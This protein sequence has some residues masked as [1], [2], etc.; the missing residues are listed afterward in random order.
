MEIIGFYTNEIHREKIMLRDI[1]VRE[2]KCLN[3]NSL[4]YTVILL[5]STS[6]TD[7]SR[8]KKR[9]NNKP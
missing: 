1:S 5:L 3:Y 6:T 4:Q 8:T 9:L 7:L 2:L